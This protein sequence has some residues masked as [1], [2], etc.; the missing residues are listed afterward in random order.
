MKQAVV[1]GIESTAHTFGAGIAASENN[2]RKI[3]ANQSAKFPTI[4]GKGY[5]PRE[6]AE[7]HAEKYSSVVQ[8]A[9]QEAGVSPSQ[10]SAIRMPLLIILCLHI[11]RSSTFL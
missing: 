6:L 8:A 4:A 9:L 2:R 11:L 5:L 7:H 1:L 3:L 10:L